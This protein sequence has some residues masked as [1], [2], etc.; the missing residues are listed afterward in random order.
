MSEIPRKWCPHKVRRD[1]K[2]LC[3]SKLTTQSKFEII[4]YGVVFLV[5]RG[6]LGTPVFGIPDFRIPGLESLS[7][8]ES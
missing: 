4:Y 3:D 8:G 1:S 6:L 7:R 2:S 5:R